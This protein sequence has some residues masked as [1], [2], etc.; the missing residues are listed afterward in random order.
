MHRPCRPGP[1]ALVT[2]AP[3][4]PGPTP[5]KHI[6]PRQPANSHSQAPHR[7]LFPERPG[8]GPEPPLGPPAHTR[9]DCTPPLE[10]TL[11]FEKRVE[12]PSRPCRDGGSG[13]RA[14][15]GPAQVCPGHGGRVEGVKDRRRAATGHVQ[16]VV[17]C[18]HPDA[19]T[20]RERLCRA[21]IAD[22][23]GKIRPGEAGRVEGEEVVQLRA[24]LALSEPFR[25]PESPGN[26]E[27]PSRER[28]V[29]LMAGGRR[30]PARAQLC[31]PHACRVEAE[32][33]AAR[34]SHSCHPHTAV[35]LQSLLVT[36]LD[37]RH[38]SHLLRGQARQR[39]TAAPPMK[40]CPYSLLGAAAFR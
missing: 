3:H 16:A 30:G 24:C 28:H 37:E 23:A 8:R 20:R 9:P 18:R 27:P 40:R 26:V 19:Q 13:R 14:S 10:E 7:A 22:G 5:L 21:R 36:L 35:N 34:I 15:H 32:E 25:T 29:E 33:I 11:T 17:Y 1:P 38:P 6:S 12:Q 39:R 31:P 4:T 2:P